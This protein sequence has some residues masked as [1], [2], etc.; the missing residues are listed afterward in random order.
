METSVPPRLNSKP[1][2]SV[3]R[4]I[5]LFVIAL[6]LVGLGF[7]SGYYLD[8]SKPQVSLLNEQDSNTPL[9]EKLAKLVVLPE[10]E[11]PSV[12]TVSDVSKLQ[13]QIFFKNAQNGDS[14]VAFPNAQI[15]IL[16]RQSANKV[17]W[18]GPIIDKQN[19][20]AVP[21]SVTP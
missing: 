8:L 17:V 12:A 11:S 7:V 21:S 13:D 2:S 10:G 5:A 20:I 9:L 3:S 1:K 6:V 14:I 4:F 18:M 19:T 15:A 16:Y